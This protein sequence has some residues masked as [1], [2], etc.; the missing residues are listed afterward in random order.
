MGWAGVKN[1]ALIEL[2][3]DQFDAIFTVDREFGVSYAGPVKIGIV[4][5][6]VG[7]TDPVKLRPYLPGVVEALTRVRPGEVRRVGA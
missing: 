3:A 1:G 5:L 2:A 7:S 6:Q 4:I